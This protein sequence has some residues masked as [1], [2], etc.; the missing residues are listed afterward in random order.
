[1]EMSPG[2]EYLTGSIKVC[3]LKNPYMDSNNPLE[4][5]L[6]DYQVTEKVWIL[7]KPRGSHTVL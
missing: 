6:R 1:M 4:L 7:S 3:K 5:S 2:F